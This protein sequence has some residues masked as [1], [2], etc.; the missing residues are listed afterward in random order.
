V[1]DEKMAKLAS[2]IVS[3][4]LYI[5]VHDALK[6]IPC[7]QCGRTIKTGEQ[8]ARGQCGERGHGVNKPVCWECNPVPERKFND[9]LT[10]LTLNWLSNRIHALSNNLKVKE[11]ICTLKAWGCSDMSPHEII[12]E[13]LI[14]LWIWEGYEEARRGHFLF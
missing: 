11:F 13:A 14:S 5:V 1:V 6:D 2:K 8:F 9:E 3:K 4:R 7:G 12:T 10:A